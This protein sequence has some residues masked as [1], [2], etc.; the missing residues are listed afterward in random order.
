[1]VRG[2]A[3]ATHQRGG[4]GSPVLLR[5]RHSQ[6]AQL[7]HGQC[8]IVSSLTERAIYYLKIVGPFVLL[9]RYFVLHPPLS[10]GV[11]GDISGTVLVYVMF[12]ARWFGNEMRRMRAIQRLVF[13]P[14]ICAIV[15]AYRQE[16]IAVFFV[17]VVCLLFHTKNKTKLAW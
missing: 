2:A 3:G 7:R 12:C 17:V 15:C 1:M 16:N 10:T 4:D 6:P 13:I 9:I 8:W 14:E 11:V 5:G